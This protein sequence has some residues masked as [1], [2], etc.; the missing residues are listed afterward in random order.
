VNCGT[1]ANDLLGG[2]IP[3]IWALPIAMP[4]VEQGK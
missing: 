1:R 3:L 2:R 4:F